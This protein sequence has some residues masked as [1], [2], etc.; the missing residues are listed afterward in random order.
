MSVSTNLI[1]GLSSGFDWR[2]MIDQLIAVDSRRVDLL[3]KKQDEYK[4][5][6]T[7]WQGV[8]TKLLALKTAATALAEE[9]TFNVYSASTTSNTTTAASS[10]LTASTSTAASPGLYNIKVNN[11]AQSEKISSTNFTASDEALSLAGDIL[12]SGKVV[13]IVATDTLAN[14]RD[15]INALNTGS[16]PSRVTASIVQHSTT[17]YHLALSSDDTGATGL[18]V[19]EASSANVL[20][21]MG[22][23]SS[24]T[25]IRNTTSD[26]AKSDLFSDSTSAVGTLL[27]LSSPPGSTT[28]Q[29]GGQDVSIDLT[30]Q[31]ITDIAA[32][33]DALAG[34]S[35]SVVSE[36]DS[37]GDVK[38]R[39]DISGTTSY[40]D[41]GNVLQMLGI[42]KGTYD[43][44]N[45]MN[46][47]NAT[48]ALGTGAAATN[49]TTWANIFT[50]SLRGS[51]Q[52]TRTSGAGGGYISA[53]TQWNQINTGGDAN[54]IDN[55]DTIRIQGKNHDGDAVDATY[56][57]TDNTEQLSAFLSWVETQY[58][59]SAAVD[60][61][62]DASGRLILE[63][64][65]SGSSQVSIDTVTPTGTALSL[66]TFG[67]N[68]TAGDTITISGT[69]HDGTAITTSAF[70]IATADQLDK[71][72]G[73][74]ETIENL[75]GGAGVVDAYISD[76]ADG[77]TAGQIVLK[78]LTAGDSLVSLSLV[79]NN[80]GG[81]SLDFGTVSMSTEGRDM[82]LAAGEDAQLTVDNVTVTKS[83]NTISDVIPGVTLNLV[84]ESASTTITLKVDRDLASI[85]TK[86]KGM[87][88]SFNTIIDYVN[89][90]FS[91]DE[92]TKEVGGILFGDGTLSSV[93]SDLISTVTATVTGLSSDYNRLALIGV[94]LDSDAKL[95]ID[96][97]ELTD[98]LTTNFDDV[99]KLFVA[100]GSSP[101]SQLQYISHTDSTQGGT[102]SVNITQAATRTTLTGSAALAGTLGAD[103]TVTVQDYATGR[104]ATVS[105]DSSMTLDDVVNA[106]NSELAKEYTEQLQGSTATGYSSSTLFSAI[107]GANNGDVITY[108]G[109]KRN[110]LA[111]SGN[112]T[113]DTTKT[114]GDLLS[115]IENDFDEEVTA[116]LDG[117]GKLII[118]DTQAG[119]SK[120]SLGI[121]TS[122][123]SGLDFGTVGT[124][125]EGRYAINITASGTGGNNLLLTH[126][127]YGAGNVI[128]VTESGGTALGLATATQVYGVNVAG[129]INGVS[130]T[131][132]A[133]T[134]ALASDGD[135]ADGLSVLYTG[136]TATTA[137]FTLTLGIGDLLDRQ[138]GFITNSTDGYVTFKQTSLGD[139][140]DSYD[141]QIEQLNAWLERKTEMMINRFVAMELAMSKIQNQS[142]WLTG[143]VNALDNLYNKS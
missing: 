98:A 77:N 97:T 122:A 99:K 43:E 81:G 101:N 142:S 124:T 118:T 26:G 22:F 126:G 20:Q 55:G 113:V 109:T 95:S 13:H 75:Y 61:Y 46:T 91:Y 108:T 76:G 132:S 10:L 5:K 37:A 4:S 28:V 114:L 83:S 41:S 84:G 88:N 111:V 107:G 27:G 104:L 23:I 39:I 33:I 63:D 125:T 2:G 56:T 29:I 52:N 70:T 134:L 8:N 116:S 44:V 105:L 50:G 138:L 106:I 59:G 115:A 21:A 102:Y 15:K 14:I 69:K 40:T 140:I 16:S 82:Q 135:N 73:F 42:L 96:D 86:I 112:Y 17:N 62:F 121:D 68:I 87:V 9:D 79:S 60:A 1:S 30:T 47:G 12:V 58:G 34:I 48:Y 119:D 90:Q 65:E 45:A 7:E 110:G 53:T 130:A 117:T 19:L 78:D 11:V 136:T 72:G 137:N 123:V 127:N 64:L 89:T 93:K 139:S 6:L 128:V 92:E 94:S 57:I 74:L 103:E 100:F 51:A 49:A 35:A 141:T 131:G 85:K 133:Q 143:Q 32:S 120:L 67:N 38:Y 31:S 66:G 3:T 71:A 25:T 129:T 18:S 54:D 36:T 24:E 80:E